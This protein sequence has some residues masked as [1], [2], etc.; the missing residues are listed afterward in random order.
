[1]YGRI[2]GHTDAP[3]K[4]AG[5]A[6]TAPDPRGNARSAASK[7][8]QARPICAGLP[9]AEPW[10]D[11]Q[12]GGDAGNPDIGAIPFG[13]EVCGVGV[14]GRIPLFGGAPAKESARV[15]CPHVGV[16]GRGDGRQT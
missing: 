6:T 12:R 5:V 7:L 15:H 2:W 3:W 9:I 1:M 4:L 8:W 11:P 10:P 16:P 13:A 14:E